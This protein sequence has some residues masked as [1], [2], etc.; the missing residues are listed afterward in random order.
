MILDDITTLSDSPVISTT[1]CFHNASKGTIFA[2]VKF[3]SS[4]EILEDMQETFPVT[5]VLFSSLL[6]VF[7][8]ISLV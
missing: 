1:D 5:G 3:L 2:D 4:S 6:L 7:S 8:F